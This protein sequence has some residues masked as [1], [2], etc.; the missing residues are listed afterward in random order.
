MHDPS[1]FHN[2]PLTGLP[3]LTAVCWCD[4]RCGS[5]SA[6]GEVVTC[7]VL[8]CGPQM[9]PWLLCAGF[10]HASCNYSWE[11]DVSLG[12]NVWDCCMKLLVLYWKNWR[13]LL[14]CIYVY[15]WVV[16]YGRSN[17]LLEKLELSK[18]RT[19]TSDTLFVWPIENHYIQKAE[20]CPSL[21]F[22]LIND[23]TDYEYEWRGPTSCSIYPFEVIFLHRR[24]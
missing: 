23:L 8:N 12:K 6:A 22:Y 2:G 3:L 18:V 21:H 20:N 1:L 5:R 15:R 13:L 24:A 17:R 10:P 16:L 9:G 7:G 11:R 14:I 19:F 4:A